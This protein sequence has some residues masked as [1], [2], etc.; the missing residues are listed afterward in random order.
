[1]K[2]SFHVTR[3]RLLAA[4]AFGALAVVSGVGYAAITDSGALITACMQKSLG[5]IR[6]Y[7]STA[8]TTSLL[9]KPCNAS[10]GEVAISW[11]QQGIQGAKGDKGDP[12][13]AGP[14]GP[15]GAPGATGPQGEKGDPGA[16]GAAGP[17][18]A[19]GPRGA[20]GPQGPAGPPGATGPQGPPGPGT[21]VMW[22]E[23]HTDGTLIRGSGIASVT[24]PFEGI[25]RVTFNS[26]VANCGIAATLTTWA[27][28]GHDASGEIGVA[29]GLGSV[30]SNQAQI[31]TF[32]SGDG[33]LGEAHQNRG[34]YIVAYC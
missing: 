25:Y 17:A 15:Q 28:E 3:M 14:P 8:P 20:T 18:G 19:E 30:P 4:V 31:D 10:L 11:N 1:V 34:F 5:T 16:P 29:A 6:M 33:I 2:I 24:H 26:S 13:A 32:N 12:G 7:D 9:G 21:N 22:A 23:I 27:G